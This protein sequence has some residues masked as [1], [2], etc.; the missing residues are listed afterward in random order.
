MV[1]IVPALNVVHIQHPAYTHPDQETKHAILITVS[2]PPHHYYSLKFHIKYI[3]QI[4]TIYY[5]YIY[6]TDTITQLVLEKR[7]KIRF[8]IL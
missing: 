2:I 6:I 3:L 8:S 1:H 4:L 7:D 5:I